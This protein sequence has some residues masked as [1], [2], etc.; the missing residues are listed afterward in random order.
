MTPVLVVEP[1]AEFDILLAYRWYEDRHVGLGT[2]FL[3][4][5]DLTFARV[6]ET[7]EEAVSNLQEA[8]AL[9]LSEF[10]LL[11]PGHPLVT[12]FSVPTHA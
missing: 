10:P 1:D 7:V 4:A 6:G 2:E 12:M 11:A 3:E 9:Y 5:L 8:T